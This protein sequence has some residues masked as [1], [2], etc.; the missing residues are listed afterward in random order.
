MAVPPFPDEPD[1]PGQP[2][3]LGAPIRKR[4]TGLIVGTIIGLAL[5]LMAAGGVGV[6]VLVQSARP[7]GTVEPRQA[8][9]GF[10][11][12]VLS[13]T[14]PEAAR[15]FVCPAARGSAQVDQLLAQVRQLE[16]TYE[17]PRLS[18]TYPTIQPQG[19]TATADVTLTLSTAND[20]TSKKRVTVLLV[21]D[22]G[23]WVCDV[24]PAANQP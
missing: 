2:G 21:E 22:R 6:F 1:E 8:V 12:A 18:W 7:R 4:R 19:R 11:G 16:E 24:E 23:W 9:E 5:V 15:G 17:S 3:E 20:Q 13:G 10:L 14:S